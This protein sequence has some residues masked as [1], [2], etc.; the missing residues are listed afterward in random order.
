[1]WQYRVNIDNFIYSD[2]HKK[3]IRKFHHYLN[4]D[5]IHGPPKES[6]PKPEDVN[7]LSDNPDIAKQK[8]L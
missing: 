4:Y 2:S 8:E 6:Q 5:S 1:V 3:V 7:M